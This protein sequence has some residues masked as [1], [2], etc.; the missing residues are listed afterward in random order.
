MVTTYCFGWQN[1]HL[2]IDELGQ[3]GLFTDKLTT[4]LPKKFS[5]AYDGEWAHI[6]SYQ[7]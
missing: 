6:D 4:L 7:L 2:S 1:N 3:Q 5:I